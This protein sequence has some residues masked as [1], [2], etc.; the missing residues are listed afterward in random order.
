MALCCC[1]CDAVFCVA[2]PTAVAPLTQLSQ[3]TS[4]GTFTFFSLG[5]YS[6]TPCA[7]VNGQA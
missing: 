4:N 3:L 7:Q 1:W 2:G 5:A 6:M